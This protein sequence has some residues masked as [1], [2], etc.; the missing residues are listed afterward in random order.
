MVVV[1]AV[2]VVLVVV[3]VTVSLVH[4]HRYHLGTLIFGGLVIG[5]IQPFRPLLVVCCL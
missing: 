2:D 1:V 4:L 3:A 5:M